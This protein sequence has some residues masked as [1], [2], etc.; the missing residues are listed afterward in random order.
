MMKMDRQVAEVTLV[1]SF[2]LEKYREKCWTKNKVF[3]L[4][5]TAFLLEAYLEERKGGAGLQAAN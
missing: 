5:E 1:E 2:D 3:D 4:V